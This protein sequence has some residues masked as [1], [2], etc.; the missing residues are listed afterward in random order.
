MGTRLSVSCFAF[1][2]SL[3]LL[4]AQEFAKHKDV[5]QQGLGLNH[6]PSI[7]EVLHGHIAWQEQSS[8]QQFL[9][10]LISLA[11]NTSGGRLAR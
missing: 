10:D 7:T 3:H 5:L 11:P 6:S 9:E 1:A 4:F 8:E 2:W